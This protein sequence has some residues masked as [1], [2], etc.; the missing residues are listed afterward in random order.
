MSTQNAK[1]RFDSQ[2]RLIEEIFPDGS[3]RQFNYDAAGNK[4]WLRR[5]RHLLVPMK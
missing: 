3:G 2:G 1:Y 4:F 5:L